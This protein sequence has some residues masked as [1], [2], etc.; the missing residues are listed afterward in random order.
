MFEA[1]P[2]KTSAQR[3]P[4]GAILVLLGAGAGPASA[5]DRDIVVVG[6]EAQVSG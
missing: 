1:I 2:M 6:H 5:A 3:L 4:L